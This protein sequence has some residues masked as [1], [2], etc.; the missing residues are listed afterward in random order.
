MDNYFLWGKLISC[1]PQNRNNYP[2]NINF[3][4]LIKNKKKPEIKHGI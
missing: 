2:Q 3:F 1:F 4:S